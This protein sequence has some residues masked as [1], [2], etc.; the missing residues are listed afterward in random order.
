MICDW[1]CEESSDFTVWWTKTYCVNE[2]DFLWSKAE[3]SKNIVIKFQTSYWHVQNQSYNIALLNELFCKSNHIT[4][5]PHSA[6]II[7][8]VNSVIYILCLTYQHQK[9]WMF[10][11]YKGSKDQI[12]LSSQHLMHLNFIMPCENTHHGMQAVIQVERSFTAK[13]QLER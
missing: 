12:R 9:Y 4:S 7:T 1:I 2:L 10:N 5:K 6:H 11:L 13:L 8:Y 3:T